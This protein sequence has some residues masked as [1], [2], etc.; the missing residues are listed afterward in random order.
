MYF[1]PWGSKNLTSLI[2]LIVDSDALQSC[3]GIAVKDRL[4]VQTMP[5]R[6]HDYGAV[7][8]LQPVLLCH[9]QEP[10]CHDLYQDGSAYV[11]EIKSHVLQYGVTISARNSDLNLRYVHSGSWQK[12]WILLH[13]EINS[14]QL[15]KY[16]S[17]GRFMGAYWWSHAVIALDWYR[18]AQHD[19]GLAGECTDPRLFLIYCR[20]SSGSRQYRQRFLAG[21]DPVL[22]NHCQIGSFH[23]KDS[24]ADCSAEYTVADH[25]Q[26]MIS[27]VLETVFD[28][29]R[30]H[31]TEKTLRPIA[32]GHPFLLAAGPGSLAVLQ[33]Y[34]FQTFSPW[35]DESYDAVS[36]PDQRL[37][38]ITREMR[39]L[40]DL[41]GDDLK[42]IVDN[43]RNIA[44]H[45]KARFFSKD[46]FNQVV[47]ELKLNVAT[48]HSMA[49]NKIDT[50]YWINNVII[51]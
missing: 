44:Q 22:A 50:Q 7:K 9:D 48:A 25:V 26:T 35:I 42:K 37:A 45:N 6:F 17:S 38:C 14:D 49:N 20:D 43:C 11:D 27:V 31:L 30:I 46:F 3:G 16:E 8:M 2:D 23:K 21:I 10:L 4:A 51:G 34:G 40:A 24:T 12:Y 33:R 41:P 47:Q 15:A 18:Y 13:S 39:R 1:Y 28:D 5:T 29:N 19:H 32:C 36:D